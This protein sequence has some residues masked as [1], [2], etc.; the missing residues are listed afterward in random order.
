M[1]RRIGLW[2]GPSTSKS[3]LA[4]WL[5]SELKT[6]QIAAEHVQE[7]VKDWTWINRKPEGLDQVLLMAMQLHKEDTI[8]RKSRAVVVSESPLRL[9]LCYARQ[10]KMP[11]L[12]HLERLADM[13]EG[14]YPSINFFIEREGSYDPTGRFENP[15]EAVA[16]DRLMLETGGVPL[17]RI[18]RNDRE[19]LIDLVL[20]AI[21]PPDPS[22]GYVHQ[23]CDRCQ[24]FKEVKNYSTF[25]FCDEC[26]EK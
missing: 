4:A 8:L 13:F 15:D 19:K 14:M 12:E 20:K 1:I 11:G 25:L 10:M 24:Q 6:K 3:T 9:G 23:Q 22:P 21:K 26:K 2:G 7:G 18:R 5:F 17:I 16:M